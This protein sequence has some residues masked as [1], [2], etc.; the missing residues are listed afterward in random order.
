MAKR[1]NF[2]RRKY[3]AY[4]TPAA[5]V[6]SL[7]PFLDGIKTYAEPCAGDGHLIVH[8]NTLA[9]LRCVYVGDLQLG[10]D[11]L[12]LD[13]GMLTGADAIITNPPWTRL[14]LHPLIDRFMRLKQ[15]WLLFDAD[16]AHTRQ[17]AGYLRHCSHIVS[18]GRVKWIP[19]T[20]HTSKDNASWFRFS[21]EHEAGPRFYGKQ[22]EE[23]EAA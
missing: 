1:S 15:T 22:I 11:A 8:L 21:I 7:L 17:A 19:G 20:A 9:G 13:E 16:W 2:P 14:L 4:H 23:E 3:D 10:Q 18:A 5:P 12:F 6:L